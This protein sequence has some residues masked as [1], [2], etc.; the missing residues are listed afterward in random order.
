[1][2]SNR[3]ITRAGS[4]GTPSARAPSPPILDLHNV[5]NNE[6]DVTP[7]ARKARGESLPAIVSHESTAYGGAGIV[8]PASIKQTERAPLEKTLENMLEEDEE[9]DELAPEPQPQQARPRRSRSKFSF[10]QLLELSLTELQLHLTVEL[11]HLAPLHPTVE[12]L[13]FAPQSLALQLKLP[14]QLPSAWTLLMKSLNPTMDTALPLE[15]LPFL[16]HQ[17]LSMLRLILAHQTSMVELVRIAMLQLPKLALH[18]P[19]ET[20]NHSLRGDRLTEQYHSLVK[21]HRSR[22]D[23]FLSDD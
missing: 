18:Q 12:L 23:Q 9:E 14:Y 6:V 19:F 22:P 10:Y 8:R 20:L 1:M 4:R 11:L 3:R 17:V 15:D 21:K 2:S 7:A 13:L 16:T 5:I